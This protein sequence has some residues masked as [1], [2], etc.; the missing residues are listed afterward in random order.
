M[1]KKKTTLEDQDLITER[2]S[3]GR[4]SS[5][6]AVGAAV[7][8]AATLVGITPS[9]AEA[10]CSD[11]DPNDPVGRGRYCGG[12]TGCTDRD[13]GDRAGWGRRCGPSGCSDS[14]PQDPGG[15]GRHCG[16]RTCSDRDPSDPVGA[17]RHC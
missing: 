3:M 12:G 16:R 14:D 2:S 15:N 5:I 17:G 8:G 10:Q 1:T 11:R 4:R 7:L 13:P 9:E 6:A